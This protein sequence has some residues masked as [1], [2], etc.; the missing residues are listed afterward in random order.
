LER[1]AHLLALISIIPGFQPKNDARLLAKAEALRPALRHEDRLPLPFDGT[2]LGKGAEL[3]LDFGEHLVGRVTL[4]L[5]T[6]GSHPDAP[7]TV[8]LFF[9][10]TLR[11][12]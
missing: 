11:E 8:K 6:A 7:A 4:T 10:E 3:L 12:P 2:P 1:K 9:A 5:G